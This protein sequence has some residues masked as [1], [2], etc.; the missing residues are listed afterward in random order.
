MWPFGCFK[1]RQAASLYGNA[2]SFVINNIMLMEGM[3]YSCLQ[4]TGGLL[5]INFIFVKP[6]E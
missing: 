3:V 6:I 4:A 5:G 2:G 1:V